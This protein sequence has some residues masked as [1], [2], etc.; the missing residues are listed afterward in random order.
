LQTK[1]NA[2]GIHCTSKK[3]AMLTNIRHKNKFTLFYSFLLKL[4][5]QI[6]K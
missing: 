5:F 3:A 1:T 6:V 4:Y 2:S